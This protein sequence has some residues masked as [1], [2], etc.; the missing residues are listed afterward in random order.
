MAK[1]K[2]C[3]TEIKWIKTISGRNM[4]CNP[5]PVGYKGRKGARD[6][7]VTAEGVV[8]ACE[9]IKPEN[10]ETAIDGF[11]YVPHWATCPGGID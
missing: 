10:G 5:E 9:I 2:L 7:V 8:I 1:C 6:R 11:G 3:G 4:P